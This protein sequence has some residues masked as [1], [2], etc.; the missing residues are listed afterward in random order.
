MVNLD[1]NGAMNRSMSPCC[2]WALPG[3]IQA[4]PFEYDN[5]YEIYPCVGFMAKVK[6][7]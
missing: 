3:D 4:D 7:L 2:M 6:A 5:G 1:L